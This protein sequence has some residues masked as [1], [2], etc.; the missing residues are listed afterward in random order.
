VVPAEGS[1]TIDWTEERVT[2]EDGTV[3]A[4]RRPRIRTQAL[5]FGEL[6]PEAS[7]S[8][9]IAPQLR[10]LGELESIPAARLEALVARDAG[11]GIRGR[12]NR[13]PG[14]SATGRFGH[15]ANVA[16]LR[17]QVAIA[18]HEDLG[19][20]STLFPMQNCPASQSAC[21]GQPHPT[22]PEVRDDQID[23]VVAMLRTLAAPRR[24]TSGDAQIRHG[25]TL[26]AS[27]NCGGC[28]IPRVSPES[29]EAYTDLLLHDLGAD[30]ADGRSEFA[31]GARD[32][33]T[34]P[35][36]GTGAAAAAGA[37][38]LH[39]G[40]ARTLEE[41]ILWHGGEAD[42]ARNRYA[43][44]RQPDRAALIRFLSTL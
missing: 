3:V 41:A 38:F 44:L 42:A 43:R 14:M 10:G 19:L 34:A 8:A 21:A 26:F 6:G 1:A 22:R 18:L 35:L 20:T 30:L 29:P 4:M 39:D 23:D 32:W 37:R 36:W 5:A 33:R 7:I 9:R 25:E 11:D 2:L 12:I 40:R 28:H 31:A 27:L 13:L 16:T 24:Q 17:E 15:K